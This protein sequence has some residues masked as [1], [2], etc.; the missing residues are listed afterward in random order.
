MEAVVNAMRHAQAVHVRM[1]LVFE[2]STVR[3]RVTDDGHGFNPDAVR[4]DASGHWGLSI[5]RERAEQV[6]GRLSIMSTP[7]RGTSIEVTAP[8]GAPA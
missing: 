6:G 2:R 5:M 4:A 1:D 3:L 7:E 8:G